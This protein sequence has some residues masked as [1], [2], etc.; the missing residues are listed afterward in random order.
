MFNFPWHYF[1]YIFSPFVCGGGLMEKF[2][3][4]VVQSDGTSLKRAIH[5]QGGAINFYKEEQE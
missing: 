3:V 2:I 5:Y 1:A 4:K